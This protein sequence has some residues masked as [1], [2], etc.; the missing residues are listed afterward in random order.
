MVCSV[1]QRK[2]CVT[3]IGQ[4][5]KAG[6]RRFIRTRQ[7]WTVNLVWTEHS[8]DHCI[9]VCHSV[10]GLFL[11]CFG[12]VTSSLYVWSALTSNLVFTFCGES[13]KLLDIILSL[14]GEDFLEVQLLFSIWQVY[15]FPGEK[16]KKKMKLNWVPT[17]A[18]NLTFSIP[19]LFI[20]VFLK[21]TFLDKLKG[22]KQSR[23]LFE[24]NKNL[25]F[26]DSMKCFL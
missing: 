22:R 16:R 2:W 12:W 5:Q 20:T 8:R 6:L 17:L 23:A 10:P 26:T 25:L 21:A 11:V 15:T 13:E 19:F 24:L 4:W 9:Q 14:M 7:G 3:R 1:W 18:I